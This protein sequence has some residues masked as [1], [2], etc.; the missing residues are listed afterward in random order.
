MHLT[1]LALAAHIDQL[2]AKGDRDGAG[3]RLAEALANDPADLTAHNLIEQ[4]LLAGNFTRWMGVPCEISPQDDIFRF[5]AGHPSS[6]NPLRDYLADGWR[7]LAELMCTLEES[8]LSLVH[9]RSFL[10]FA[11]GHGRFTRHLVRAL[12]A[13]ALSVSDVVP[14]SVDFLIRTMGVRGFYSASDPLALA[15]PQRYQ[16]VFALSLFSHLPRHTWG[17]WLQT[18]WSC[19]EAGGL[20]IVSTHGEASAADAGVTLPADGFH[21]LPASE[22]SA[23]QGDEYGC[24]YTSEAFVRS[25]ALA[26]LGADVTVRR[27][28]RRFW[29]SQDGFVFGAAR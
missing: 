5:F 24:T 29:N 18:L 20:L 23:L 22:S 4:H 17:R 11:C 16:V 15:A 7:T 6:R 3:R 14:G 13:G 12:P 21:Y 9:C 27:A 25:T 26:M 10:E 19:V 2:L 8:G 1:P 28:P